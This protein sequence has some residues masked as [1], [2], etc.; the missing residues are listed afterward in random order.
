MHHKTYENHQILGNFNNV[1][2]SQNLH[3]SFDSSIL[4][5]D[6]SDHLPSLV[7]I[8]NQSMDKT[9]HWELNCRSLNETK[10]IEINK[11]LLSTN[12][13]T[14]NTPDVNKSFTELKDR[15]EECMNAIAPLKTIKIP[16][17]KVWHEPWITKGISN[18]MNHCTHLYKKSLKCDAKPD[19]EI[20]YKN[21]RNCFTKIKRKAKAEYYTNRCYALK[22][23]MKRLWQLIN[24]IINKSNDKTSIIEYITVKN[25]QY[26]NAKDVS[27]QF[28]IYYS[29]LGGKLSR[30]LD[31][32]S[33]SITEYLKKI[34][35]NPKSLFWSAITTNEIHKHID[36][37]PSKNSSGYDKISNILLKRIKM[38]ISKPLSIIFNQSLQTGQ[39][40]ENMKITEIIP[41][42]KRGTKHILENYRPISLLI[43]L[44]K[45]LEKCIYQR[46]YKFLNNN[47][48]IFK[49]QYSF[50]AQHSCEHAIQDLCGNIISK[51][52]DGLHTAAIF[53]DLSKAFDTL[54]HDILL[55]KL[56]IYGI[57]GICN[58]WFGSYLTDRNIQVKCKTLSSNNIETSNRYRINYGTA[59]GSCLG[60]LLF[61]IFCN[62][63]YY[64]IEHSDLILFVDDT[65]VYASHRNST[66]LNYI[67]QYDFNNLQQWFK[68]NKLTL[69]LTKTVTMSFWSEQMNNPIKILTTKEPL[70]STRFLGVII[71]YK[72]S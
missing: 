57:R 55:K 7:T 38:S 60:P 66:F 21:Y 26:H 52:E 32:G 39:F 42:F 69:N 65:T 3:K 13:S 71:D 40:P 53:L 16:M 12:W 48:I 9:D 54:S 68:A 4:L 19:I 44:S 61:N 72:L 22:S 28:G 15:I 36:K 14:L 70:P 30:E 8:H 1:F 63:I 33:V 41:L 59:Q 27:N 49:K 18:S 64:N 45:L 67:L 47:N 62:D 34:K 43:T 17:H 29:E 50:R 2:I 35:S 6:I 25:I 10:M 51:K 11:L 20:K 5:N 31:T 58:N 56:D 24:N 23:N 37:L 46:V